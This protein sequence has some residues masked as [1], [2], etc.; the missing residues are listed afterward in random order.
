MMSHA[1]RGRLGGLAT[2]RKHD[3]S[4]YVAIGTK[5]VKARGIEPLKE[6]YARIEQEEKEEAY[7]GNNWKQ[8]FKA[9]VPM[10]TKR[11]IEK[12]RN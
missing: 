4:F 5:G 6:M 3:H 8:Q 2:A 7:K 11:S 9:M 12:I 1:E 10:D